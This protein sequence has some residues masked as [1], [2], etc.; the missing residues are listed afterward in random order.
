[1]PNGIIV[2]YEY[3]QESRLTL[4]KHELNDVEFIKLK[5]TLDNK[6]NRISQTNSADKETQH[7]YDKKD[8]LVNVKYYDNTIE[9]YIYDVF[10]N[11]VALQ[12]SIENNMLYTR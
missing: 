10:G 6:G 8:Q 2:T 4:L 12:E 11:H 7:Q 9:Q 3:D 5:Y 1:M